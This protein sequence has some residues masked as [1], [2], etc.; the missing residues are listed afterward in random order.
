MDKNEVKDFLDETEEVKDDVLD[1]KDPDIFQEDDVKADAKVEDKDEKPVPF[2]Q[3]PKIQRYIAKEIAKAT[4][5][6]TKSEA[7]EFVKETAGADADEILASLTEIVGN[8]TPQKIAATNRLRKALAGLED[9]GAEKALAKMQAERQ[10]E[11]EADKAAEDELEQGFESVEE[12]FEVDITSNTPIARKTRDEFKAFI[13]RVAPK[14]RDGNVSEYPDF[15]ETFKLFQETKAKPNVQ[16][17]RSKDLASRSMS[18]SADASNAPK[19]K[20]TSWRGV[21]RF[22]S[23][24]K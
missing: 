6:L 22:L 17:S 15:I 9:K 24:L 20:D 10:A 8:D 23:G 13:A 3:D 14:D 21:E 16:A 18:R 7:K 1:K 4:Q 2:H 19:V 11:A 5:G 12:S